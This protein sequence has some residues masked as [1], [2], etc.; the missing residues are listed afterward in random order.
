[1][2]ILIKK[3][4]KLF[5]YKFEK[6]EGSCNSSSEYLL[7]SVFDKKSKLIIFDIGAHIGESAKKY[8]QLF[9]N[10]QIYSFEPSP[11][12]YKVL[13]TLNFKNLKV[14]NFG[15]SNK[16]SK[17]KFS[18]NQKS[19]TNSLLLFAKNANKQWEINSLNNLNTIICEFNTIDNFCFEEKLNLIDFMKIDVQGAEYLVL[20]GAHNTLLNKKIK[21]I[22]LEVIIC[23]TYESQKTIGF[24]INFLESYG[25]RFL[26]FSDSVVRSGTLIQSDLFF[27][28]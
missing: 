10:S 6:I 14:Y 3:I 21:L 23:K 11:D 8:C 2:K 19:D 28:I 25:Y 1:L 22:Q 7:N 12:S 4:F 16:K 5:G 17:E 18:V 27:T 13:N 9:K 20:E 26:N 24:Y 15:F